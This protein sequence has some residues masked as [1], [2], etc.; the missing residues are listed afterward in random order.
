MGIL[1]GT[2]MKVV[3]PVGLHRHLHFPKYVL[4]FIGEISEPMGV[5]QGKRLRNMI[6]LLGLCLAILDSL[7]LIITGAIFT[8]IY[9]ADSVAWNPHKMLLAGIQC[10]ALLVKDNAVSPP[11]LLFY[12]FSCSSMLLL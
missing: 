12:F 1:P 8:S 6:C 7:V 10:C 5:L 3:W 9:R 4:L 11:V 2:E